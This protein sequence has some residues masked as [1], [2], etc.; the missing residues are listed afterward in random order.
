MLLQMEQE[1]STTSK[2]GEGHKAEG[3][4][5]CWGLPG[6]IQW[7]ND[8]IFIKNP[9]QENMKTTVQL[10]SPQSCRELC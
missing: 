5:V 7:T 6:D 8:V 4:C 2:G 9:K 10:Q 3:H 1:G